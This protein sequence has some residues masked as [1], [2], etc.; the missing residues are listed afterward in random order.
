MRS[1]AAIIVSLAVLAALALLAAAPSP[2]PSPTPTPTPTP[3][4]ATADL[5][6]D[7][8][9]IK[10]Q[11]TT[12]QHTFP[13]FVTYQMHE[14]FDHRGQRE[15]DDYRVWY[16]GDGQGLMQ[17][18]SKDHFGRAETYF[19]RPFPIEPVANIILY[20][21]P[22][23]LPPPPPP[24]SPSPLPSGQTAP[25]VLTT[26]SVVGDRYYT[27]QLAGLEI[28]DGH[29]VFHLTMQALTDERE[30]P[31]KD[32][33]VDIATF[34]VW[35]AH[36]AAGG[37]KGAMTGSVDATSEFEPVSGYWVIKHM[38]ADGEGHIGIRLIGDSAHY[39]YTF[40]AFGFP[41]YVPDWYFDKQK[42]RHH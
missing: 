15:E 30:H 20:A 29:A 41:P 6:A 22:A 31:L 5:T 28:Y 23:P 16:R 19:G 13:A 32:L 26:Q 40:S 17:N 37:T 27:V 7:Q 39:E 21:T 18:L 25:P 36:V 34:E 8:I 3:P 24:P 35:K 12:R 33:W 38:V 9:L 1:H 14:V 10:A 11:Q 4:P 2:S 42:F